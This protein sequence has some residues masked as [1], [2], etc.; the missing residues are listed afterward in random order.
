MLLHQLG[1]DLVLL[2]ELG[3]EPLDE[4]CLK[5]LRPGWPPCRPFQSALGLVEH[6]FDPGVDLAGLKAELIGQF[7]NRLFATDVATDNL[8]ECPDRS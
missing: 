6:L 5:S 2:E 7:G 1:D 4:L 3:L 8:R